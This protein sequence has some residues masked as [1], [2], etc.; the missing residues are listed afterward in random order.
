MTLISVVVP[1]YNEEAVIPELIRRLNDAT[2]SGIDATFE[3]IFVDDGS[4]DRSLALL[5]E[6]AD[7]NSAIKVVALSRNFGHQ[8]ALLAGLNKASGDAV[9]SLDADLQDPPELIPLLIEK[10]SN[11][12]DIVYAKRRLRR[13]ENRFKLVTASLFYRLLDRLSDTNLPRDV[14]DYRLISRHVLDELLALQ[15]RS[16]YLRGMVAWTGFRQSTVEYDR[17]SRFAGTTKYPLK[18]MVGLAT[19]ALLSFSERPLRFVTRIG[20]SITAISFA[21]LIFVLVTA[22]F[23]GGEPVRGWLS[24]FAAVLTLGG[25]QIICIGI[26][27]E[28]ISRIY[29]DTKKRPLYI[30][31]KKR[32]KLDG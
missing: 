24:V 19:D 16:L 11:G 12:S 6:F 21:F 32:S 20:L 26:V 22:I 10:W 14:G 15:E 23:G 3:L 17:E 18:K 7:T 27:G 5:S 13:G 4:S 2:S 28:Y 25:V 30:V 31:D 8:S 29:R 9:I 1:V